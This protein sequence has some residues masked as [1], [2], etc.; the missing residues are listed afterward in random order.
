MTKTH[1][2]DQSAEAVEWCSRA[3]ALEG[4]DSVAKARTLMFLGRLRT[5]PGE[6][7]RQLGELREAQAMADRLNDAGT[8]MFALFLE[9]QVGGWNGNRVDSARVLAQVREYAEGADDPLLMSTIRNQY[10]EL[11]RA[12]GTRPGLR[13]IRR[14]AR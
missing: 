4:P 9:T 7:E 8:A 11:A 6:V 1:G 10:G 2:S 3:L 14:R 12:H 13:R 5:A